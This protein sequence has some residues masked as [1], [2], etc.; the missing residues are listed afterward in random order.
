LNEASLQER[1]AA[2]RAVR[3]F[4]PPSKAPMHKAA[5]IE[6]AE[7]AQPWVLRP[8]QPPLKK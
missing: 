5:T 7:K 4:Y 2:S 8:S 3:K 1:S 6:T